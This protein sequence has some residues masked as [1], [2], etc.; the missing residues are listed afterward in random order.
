MQNIFLHQGG[1]PRA[2]AP[3]GAERGLEVFERGYGLDVN[4]HLEWD[5]LGGGTH[6]ANMDKD[7]LV[8]LASKG[9]T[10]IGGV[11]PA[12]IIQFLGLLV[13]GHQ[14]LLGTIA[15]H[16]GNEVS[17]EQGRSKWRIQ[18][19]LGVLQADVLPGVNLRRLH[20]K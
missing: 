18:N 2:A 20:L 6:Y 8:G 17:I 12:F 1:H 5:A 19:E 16:G 13:I 14:N 7:H 9:F 11:V 10:A 4:P 15:L 3:P